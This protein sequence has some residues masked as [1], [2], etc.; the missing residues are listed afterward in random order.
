MRRGH[1]RTLVA[2]IVVIAMVVGSIAFA[3]M[4]LL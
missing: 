1:T 3:L 2:A 4:N